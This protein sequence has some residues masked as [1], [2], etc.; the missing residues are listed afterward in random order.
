VRRIEAYGDTHRI[1]TANQR[2]ALAARDRG[3]TFPGCTSGPAWCEAHHVIDYADGGR[4]SVVNGT[5]L[6]PY[7]H[8]HFARLGYRCTM[9]NGNPHW[10]APAWI[11]PAGQSTDG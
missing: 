5:L 7:H 11:D 9:I 8:R 2:L 1:F 4:T 6:C 10:I 3:C